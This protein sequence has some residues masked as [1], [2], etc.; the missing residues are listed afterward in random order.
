MLQGRRNHAVLHWVRVGLVLSAAIASAPLLAQT[1]QEELNSPGVYQ[2]NA[3]AAHGRTTPITGA[4]VTIV[5]VDSGLLATHP[6][7]TGRVLPGY[8]VFDGSQNTHDGNG[9]GTHVAG[10]LGAGKNNPFT[11]GMFGVA[12]NVNLM[13][14]RALNNFGFGTNNGISRGIQVAVNRRNNPA[15]ADAQSRSP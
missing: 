7:F 13:P 15:V 11:S 6:E 12:Y 8:N 10:I 3:N 2:I 9:H 5:I 4:N 1:T 14:I